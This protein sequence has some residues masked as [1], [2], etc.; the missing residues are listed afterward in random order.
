MSNSQGRHPLFKGAT[1]LPTWAGV[2]RTIF[3][4][5]FMSCAAL[6]PVVHFW[7]VGLFAL[8]FAIEWCICRHDDRMFRII[9]LAWQ[10]KVTNKLESPFSSLWGGSS[11]SPRDYGGKR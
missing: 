9:G 6:F 4:L 11:Y 1:R 2:P 8:L 5:T 3:L 7:A 10:T